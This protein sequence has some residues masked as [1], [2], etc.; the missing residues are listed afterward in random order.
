ME[1]IIFDEILF[2]LIVRENFHRDGVFFFTDGSASLEMG[3]MSHP[4]GHIIKPH[5]HLPYLRQTPAT[6]EVL[7]LKS[8]RLRINFFSNLD[9]NIGN[10]ELKSGDWILLLNGGHSFDILEPSILF[11][12]K[13]G[14]YAGD[15]DK[16]RFEPISP[17]KSN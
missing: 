2:A 17:G 12:I 8:G 7:F 1:K 13:N 4:A 14:P 9:I 16:I 10:A 6:Q 3:Y 11:E 5:K 15:K